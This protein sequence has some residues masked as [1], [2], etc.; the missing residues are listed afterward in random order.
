[1]RH[2]PC[3]TIDEFWSLLDPSNPLD[4][5][6]KIEER[7]RL[8]YRGQED[9]EFHL[10]PASFRRRCNPNTLESDLTA[11]EQ[12]K[13]EYEEFIHFIDSS[14]YNNLINKNIYKSHRE[15]FDNDFERELFGNPSI[16]PPKVIF[17][18]LFLAQHHGVA[19]QLLDWT[20]MPYAAVYFACQPLLFDR[21]DDSEKLNGELA[22]WCYL[23]DEGEKEDVYV[24]RY[25]LNCDSNMEAQK[26]HFILIKQDMA[27]PHEKF[28][29]KTLDTMKSIKNLWKVTINK[30]EVYELMSKC[31]ANRFNAEELYKGRGLDGVALSYREKELWLSQLNS[32]A[33]YG[34][35]SGLSKIK[36]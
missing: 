31:S 4:L 25:T 2:I 16:W 14:A 12:V 17:D 3:K 29:I 18:S 1:M 36:S 30:K 22:V 33:S 13:K 19:T 9:A 7:E 23:P 32:A 26:G 20:E 10:L 6:L 27:K 11:E 21:R 8:L 24:E 35:R 28:N 15:L 5:N 34:S